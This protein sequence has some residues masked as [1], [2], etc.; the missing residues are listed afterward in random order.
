[1]RILASIRVIS[2]IRSIAGADNIELA[3]VDGWQCVV[4]KGEFKADEKVIYCEVDSFLPVK[5]QYEFLRKSSYR[6]MGDQEGFRI[7]TIKLRGQISQGLIVPITNVNTPDPFTLIVGTD[8]SDLLGIVKWE[9]PV[10]AQ[11]AGEVEGPFPSF[12][13]KTDEER[14]QNLIDNL[15]G[16][17]SAGIKFQITEKLDGTSATYY[18][19]DGKY[20]VCSRNWE[21]KHDPNNT[22]WK[23]AEELKLEEKLNN[24][25]GNLA[26]QGELAGPGIQKNI[27]KLKKPQLFVFNIWDIDARAYFSKDDMRDWCRKY[28]LDMVPEFPER[29]TVLELEDMLNFADGKSELGDCKREGLVWTSVNS[30]NRISFKV[31]SNQYLL[32]EDE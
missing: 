23:V 5:P 27:Y 7:K 19:K 9:P 31:I 6:K 13:R 15:P 18:C 32:E 21:L 22:F 17:K 10:P 29:I 24:Y 25:K 12:I 3:V 4:K 20:G 30:P 2:E 8:V 16:W 11:L 14:I 26:L 28:D 1:M